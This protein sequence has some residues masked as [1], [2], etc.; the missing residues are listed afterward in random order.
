[1][2]RLRAKLLDQFAFNEEQAVRKRASLR[3]KMISKK[4]ARKKAS[5]GG[6]DD[7]ATVVKSSMVGSGGSGS[8]GGSGGQRTAQMDFGEMK[9]KEQVLGHEGNDFEDVPAILV[10]RG[11]LFS[12]DVRGIRV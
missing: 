4:E 8:T 9:L 2:S 3:E 1:M 6:G 12:L 10:F 11:R 5:G 7:N